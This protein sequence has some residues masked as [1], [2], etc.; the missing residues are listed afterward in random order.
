L[1][2]NTAALKKYKIS[3]IWSMW[4]LSWPMQSF[5]QQNFQLIAGWYL[6]IKC[7]TG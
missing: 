4:R 6:Q 7:K 1:T 3:S 2:N 5:L